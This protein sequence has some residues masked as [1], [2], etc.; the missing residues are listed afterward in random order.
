MSKIMWQA[1]PETVGSYKHVIQHLINAGNTVFVDDTYD[2]Q[3]RFIDNSYILRMQQERFDLGVYTVHVDSPHACS[4]VQKM[5]SL[6]SVFM[7]HDIL[8]TSLDGAKPFTPPNSNHYAMP[9]TEPQVQ[10]CKKVGLKYIACE[11]Y[12]TNLPPSTFSSGCSPLDTALLVDSALYKDHIFPHSALFKQVVLKRFDTY[13]YVPR[14]TKSG[15]FSIGRA[16]QSAR[17]DKYG[18]TNVPTELIG[19]ASTKAAASCS[20]F[21]FTRESS[22]YT[23]ALFEGCI[24]ILYNVERLPEFEL[25]AKD[26]PYIGTETQQDDIVSLVTLTLLLG[27]FPAITET[28]LA[29]KIRAL[30]QSSTLFTQTLNTLLSFWKVKEPIKRVEQALTEILRYPK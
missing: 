5:G 29:H 27:R 22:L 8:I 12:K 24:P 21:W 30:Q 17:L 26:K 6:R 28:N 2:G 11:W 15:A 19:P 23:E 9:F 7:P 3:Q 1:E 18:I 10:Y 25:T 13:D 16:G 14:I 4:F 20:K